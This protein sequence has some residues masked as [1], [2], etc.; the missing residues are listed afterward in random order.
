MRGRDILNIYIEEEIDIDF[1][2]DVKTILTS[3]IEESLDYLNC[4][5]EAEVNV[6]LTDN[7]SIKEIN[8]EQRNID[9]PTDVLSFPM[10]EIKPPGN[11]A[12]EDTL[13]FNPESG[14]LILGDI[15]ISIDKVKEQAKLYNHSEL[16]EIAFLTAHSMLHLS[17]FDHIDD[18]ERKLM[19]EKQKDILERL[20]ITRDN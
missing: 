16:R 1:D 2:F 5:Y 9:N 20:N 18:S 3:V 13:C 11:F 15:V 7:E 14:E 12:D 8:K 17:G 10:N 4:P 6:L 19:E